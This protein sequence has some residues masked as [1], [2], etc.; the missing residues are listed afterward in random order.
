MQLMGLGM[1]NKGRRI[2]PDGEPEQDP[3]ETDRVCRLSALNHWKQNDA[4]REAHQ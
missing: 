1:R 2:G 4:A 3:K